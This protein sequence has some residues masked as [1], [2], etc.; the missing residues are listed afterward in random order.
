MNSTKDDEET[1]NANASLHYRFMRWF[2]LSGRYV[3]TQVVSNDSDDE[4][5]NHSFF[6][7]LGASRELK[8]WIHH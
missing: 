1:Y 8:R 4:Y 2:Y 7:R 3:Y 6:I 5:V